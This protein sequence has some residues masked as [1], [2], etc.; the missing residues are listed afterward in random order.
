L[1][2]LSETPSKLIQASTAERFVRSRLHC[3]EERMPQ[4]HSSK[5]QGYRR[6][7]KS[8]D[9][10]VAHALSADDRNGLLRI[11]DSY[12]ALAANEESLDRLPPMPPAHTAAMMP[13]RH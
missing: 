12:L 13:L 5:A 11:R 8:C 4:S 9:G 10:L 7:A 1:G 3:K 2:A 6:K